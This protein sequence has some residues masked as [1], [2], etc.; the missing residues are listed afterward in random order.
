MSE[1]AESDS[2]ETAE[3]RFVRAWLTLKRRSRTLSYAH[4]SNFSK[5]QM[6]FRKLQMLQAFLLACHSPY[7]TKINKN[8]ILISR[9]LLLL[10]A[11]RPSEYYK[12]LV[13][14]W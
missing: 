14:L 3:S 10:I 13:Y 9:N 6:S 8:F 7:E 5:P 2:E 1:A 4:P 12:A 11:G